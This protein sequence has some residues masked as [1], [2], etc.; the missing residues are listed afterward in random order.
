MFDNDLF[1]TWLDNKSKEIMLR[2]DKE[3][4]STEDMMVLMLKAQTNHFAHLDKN[5]RLEM[6]GLSANLRQEM[7]GLSSSLRQEMSGLGVTLG[8]EIKTL[9]AELRH[10]IQQRDEKFQLEMQRSNDKFQ[11][12]ILSL[13]KDM[14]HV[15]CGGGD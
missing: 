7:G 5:L 15:C 9:N 10:E 12:E 4:L 13:R 2:V 1:D 8:Q 3:K 14:D 11:Q 6:S